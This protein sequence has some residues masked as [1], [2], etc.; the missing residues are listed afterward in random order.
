VADFPPQTFVIS[1]ICSKSIVINDTK[2]KFQTTRISSH[3][4]KLFL[5]LVCYPEYLQCLYSDTIG[6]VFLFKKLLAIFR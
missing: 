5:Y 3:I 1:V 4:E 2:L 6:G